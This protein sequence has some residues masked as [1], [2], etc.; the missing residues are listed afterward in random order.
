VAEADANGLKTYTLRPEDLDLTPAPLDAII[1]GEPEQNAELIRFVLD[2][3]PGPHRDI[4]ILN[5]A[6]GILAGGSEADWNQA[7]DR[8]AE[9]IDS[10]AAKETLAKLIET[11]QATEPMT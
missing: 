8:A 5:A 6:A 10:G 4:V 11:S 2:G 9:A 7:A 3:K 1:G